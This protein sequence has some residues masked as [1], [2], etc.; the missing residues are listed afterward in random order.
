MQQIG[1]S[2]KRTGWR[3]W[4]SGLIGFLLLMYVCFS[5][6]KLVT[7]PLVSFYQEGRCTIT[8]DLTFHD[9]GIGGRNGRPATFR[10]EYGFTLQTKDGQT[11]QTRGFDWFT[12]PLDSYNLGVWFP[13]Y[14]V[15]QTIPCWYNPL[16]HSQAVLTRDANWSALFLSSTNPV[17]RWA[18]TVLLI[19][20]FFFFLWLSL[21]LLSPIIKVLTPGYWRRR[22]RALNSLISSPTALSPTAA[23]T[24]PV[25]VSALA[26]AY[27]L[28]T[29]V[30]EYV[31]R[32]RRM[33]FGC[34]LLIALALFSLV[35]FLLVVLGLG[36]LASTQVLSLNPAPAWLSPLLFFLLLFSLV[37]GVVFFSLVMGPTLHKR[38]QADIL[39]RFA[40]AELLYTCTHGLLWIT[41]GKVT[42]VYPWHLLQDVATDLDARGFPRMSWLSLTDGSR[43]PLFTDAVPLVQRGL[44]HYRQAFPQAR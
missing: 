32:P 30:E 9:R 11:T 14:Q 33:G 38:Q 4:W 27:R 36:L 23:D 29:P 43:H 37:A 24:I 20:G 17:Y 42:A 8:A 7:Y 2:H 26:A 44:I 39:Y 31:Q 6:L 5:A 28:G 35:F 3:G 21:A 10:P 34:L 12:N 13:R 41:R 16:D 40:R 1:A 25:E 15:G 19:S 22:E 18:G